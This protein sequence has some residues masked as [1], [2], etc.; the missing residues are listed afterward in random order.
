ML[1]ELAPQWCEV[2]IAFSGPAAANPYAEV[3][4][5]VIFTHTNGRPSLAVAVLRRGWSSSFQLLADPR[6]CQ[7]LKSG[8]RPPN[9]VPIEFDRYP[10]FDLHMHRNHTG[11]GSASG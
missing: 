2:D 8:E 5:W 11:L 3:E 7:V 4:A 10:A 1:N 9:Y 6:T